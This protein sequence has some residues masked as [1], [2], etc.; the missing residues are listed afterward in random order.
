M[1]LKKASLLIFTLVL[2][3]FGCY[4]GFMLWV[5]RGVELSSVDNM[6]VFGDSF[7]MIT[8][9]FSGLAFAGLIL[10][11]LLQR[12]ELRESREIFRKQKF[13][14][15][16]YRLLDFYQRNLNGIQ[17]KDTSTDCI[18]TGVGAFSYLLSRL[19]NTMAPFN[20]YLKDSKT[21]DIYEYHFFIEIQRVLTKQ[22]RY[23]GTLE[24]IFSIIEQDLESKEEKELYWKILAS[25]LT[26]YELKYIIF[27]SLVSPKNNKLRE[28]LHD[29]NVISFRLSDV[30]VSKAFTRIYKKAH[31][32]EIKRAKSVP[33][34]PFSRDEVKNIKRKHLNFKKMKKYLAKE[35]SNSSV[36]L[37]G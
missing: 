34:L 13:E 4:A 32:V 33:T 29:S 23:L 11:V 25:Q 22:A 26:S 16:F 30:N 20:E 14:D 21:F 37:K 7:G 12:E 10:T 8:S 9:L 17:V 35:E 18:H 36:L 5:T 28:Y 19:S 31:G 6:G 1:N 24:S 15:A 3:L 27:Q 2:G